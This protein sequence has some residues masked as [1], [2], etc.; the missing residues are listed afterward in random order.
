MAGSSPH[1]VALGLASLTFQG[2]G[3]VKGEMGVANFTDNFFSTAGEAGRC[4]VTLSLQG[5][6]GAG[7]K[8]SLGVL[9]QP[10]WRQYHLGMYLATR[11]GIEAGTG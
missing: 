3:A 4:E 9:I 10:Q 11:R 8:I 2:R 7:P 5:T 6:P 1:E